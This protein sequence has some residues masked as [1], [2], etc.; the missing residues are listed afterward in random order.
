MTTPTRA[1]AR[2][3]APG[4]HRGERGRAAGLGHDLHALE[5]QPHGVDDLGVA[6]GDDV[7]DERADD[8]PGQLARDGDLLAV[9]DRLGHLDR[10]ALAGTQR[11]RHVVAGLGL[12]ADHAHLRPQRLDRR[13][14]PGDQPAAADRDDHRVEVLD[15]GGELERRR[16]PGRPSRAARRRGARASARARRRARAASASRSSA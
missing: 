9:G 10:H 15:L 1:A 4:Q 14:H 16:C 2:A 5:E 12:D 3:A 13:R 7:V 11:A 6:D 8:L